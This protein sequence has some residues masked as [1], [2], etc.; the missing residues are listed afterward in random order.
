M[1]ADPPKSIP[2]QHGPLRSGN[3]VTSQTSHWSV[4]KNSERPSTEVRSFR[5][6]SLNE[7]S[8]LPPRAIALLA[9]SCSQSRLEPIPY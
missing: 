3:S 4:V 1:L 8:E 7:A 6:K 9:A 5:L 2:T